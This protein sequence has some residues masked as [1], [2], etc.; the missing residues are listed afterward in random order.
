VGDTVEKIVEIG[1]AYGT[2]VVSD[3]RRSRMQRVF[4]GSIATDVVRRATTS[5]LDVR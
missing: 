5:V 3:E 4:K 1:N 2:I